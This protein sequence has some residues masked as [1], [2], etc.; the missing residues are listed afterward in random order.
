[1][2]M[3]GL[4]RSQCLP[5][6][7]RSAENMDVLATLYKHL[8]RL[9]LNPNEPDEVLLGTLTNINYEL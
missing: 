3:W 9:T 6:F 8:T 5:V 1:M 2:R 7:S 4:V